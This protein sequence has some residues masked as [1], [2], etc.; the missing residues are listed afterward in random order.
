MSLAK[1]NLSHE[2]FTLHALCQPKIGR[3]GNKQQAPMYANAVQCNAAQCNATWRNA[4]GWYVL[5]MLCDMTGCKPMC[6]Y[7]AQCNIITKLTTHRVNNHSSI[8]HIPRACMS[9][10]QT[11][12]PVHPHMHEML[13]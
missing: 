9:F 8:A 6:R 5:P 10:C 7:V 11:I 12:R 13:F 1:V 2:S 4:A 3:P